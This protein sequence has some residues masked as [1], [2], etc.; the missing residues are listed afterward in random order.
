[1][2]AFAPL[3][4]MH[5]GVFVVAAT[6]LYTYIYLKC[7]ELLIF[8]SGSDTEALRFVCREAAMIVRMR[9]LPFDCTEADIVSS[10]PNSS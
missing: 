6:T 1:M 2:S 10:L 9:G 8:I 3:F 4:H 7:A 5:D